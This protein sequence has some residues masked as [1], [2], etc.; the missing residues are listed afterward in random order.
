MMCR[1][2]TSVA[3]LTC[4]GVEQYSL[5]NRLALA[6]DVRAVIFEDRKKALFKVFLKRLRKQSWLTVV[7]QMMFKVLDVLFFQKN[8]AARAH[9]ILGNQITFDASKFPSTRLLATDSINSAECMELMREASPDVVVVSGVSLL[10]N[11]LLDSIG[12]TPVVNIHCGVTPRYRGAHGAFWGVVNGD[13]DNVGTTVHLIDRGID[14]GAIL[15]QKA[16]NV[17]ADDD[18]RTLALKQNV[19][20]IELMVDAISHLSTGK[21]Q[22]VERTDLDSRLYSSPT[23][24]AYLQYRRRIADR[25]HTRN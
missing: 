17:E 12:E 16:I 3:I 19:A 14:T 6:Y 25:F 24:T 22:T 20:G 1:D 10:S 5:V 15:A 21:W 18:P 8:A 4:H 7:D 2:R 11:E 9:E 13:W 23:L